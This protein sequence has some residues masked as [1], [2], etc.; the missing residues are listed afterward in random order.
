MSNWNP[1]EDQLS[2]W[3]PRGPSAKLKRRLFGVPESGL[4]EVLSP[5]GGRWTWLA[6]VMGCFLVMM[7]ISGTRSYELGYLS[8]RPRTDWLSAVTSNQSYAAYIASAFHS[9]QNSLQ[10][11]PIEWTNGPRTSREVGP[12]LLA[13]TNS[14]I[15]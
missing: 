7:V 3:A 10:K 11:D 8:A 1:I 14:L 12:V 6:P 2:S 15:H 9:E 4:S 13:K 5:F